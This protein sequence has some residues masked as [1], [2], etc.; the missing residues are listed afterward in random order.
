MILPAGRWTNWVACLVKLDLRLVAAE[1]VDSLALVLAV[2]LSLQAHDPQRR[3]GELIGCAEVG[4]FVLSAVGQQKL[5]FHPVDLRRRVRLDV[6]LQVHVVVKGLAQLRS[7]NGDHGRKL[8]FQVDVS[9]VAFA[10]AVVSETII[11]AAIFLADRV[12][13]QNVTVVSRST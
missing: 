7:R 5:V 8:D 9:T 12:N 11:S 13:L 10:D 3:V 2:L 6:A 4:N 1:L